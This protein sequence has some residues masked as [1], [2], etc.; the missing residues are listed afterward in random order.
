MTKH[1][2]YQYQLVIMFNFYMRQMEKHRNYKS[3]TKVHL[4]WTNIW[5]YYEILSQQNV[6]QMQY[7]S[8]D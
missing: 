2:H 8:I 7:I 1:N 6:W 3:N 5:S 4:S